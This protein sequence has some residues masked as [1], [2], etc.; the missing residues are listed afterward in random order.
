MLT[1]DNYGLTDVLRLLWHNPVLI[2][3][4]CNMGIVV[5]M[6]FHLIHMIAHRR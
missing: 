1:L 4:W 2:L 3:L 6:L 5:G